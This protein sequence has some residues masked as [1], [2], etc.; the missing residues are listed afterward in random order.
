MHLNVITTVFNILP[1]LRILYRFITCKAISD[2][3]THTHLHTVVTHTTVGAAR[4]SVKVAGGT[5]LHPQLDSLDRHV[6]IKGSADVI[7]LIFIFVSY[8]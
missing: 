2:T 4:G 5:P 6:F 1:H 3:H 8:K 7:I